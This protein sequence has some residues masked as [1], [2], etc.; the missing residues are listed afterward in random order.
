MQIRQAKREY[1]PLKIGIGGISNSGKTRGALQTAY[2]ITGN[3]A[4]IC[5]IDTE[6]RS[7]DLYAD[8]GPYD[9]LSLDD[10]SAQGYIAAINAVVQAGTYKVMI[11]DSLTHEWAGKGG[12]LEAI[13]KINATS[14]GNKYTAWGQATPLH[15]SFVET[16]LQAK[17]HT[18]ATMRKKDEYV[19]EQNEK[20]KA[21]PKKVGLK[22]IQRDGLDFEFDVLLSIHSNHLCTVEKDRTRLF[23]GGMPFELSADIGKKLIDWSRGDA[24]PIAGAS[25][26][27]PAPA[28]T[29]ANTAVAKVY[30]GTTEQQK[31]VE[32]FL[33]KNMIDA[34]HWE[35]IHK[36]LMGKPSAELKS[37]IREVS[38]VEL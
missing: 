22:N 16:W 10:T 38:G 26:T 8:M 6:N 11:L 34:A 7:A 3:W 37:I 13:E 17:I 36:R 30:S 25:R 1:R 9:V 5:V 12:I 20:G 29:P 24:A 2:G 4:E 32:G 14:A 19:I 27:T 28:I 21:V 33:T 35:S 23:D 18:I 31:Y 15:N